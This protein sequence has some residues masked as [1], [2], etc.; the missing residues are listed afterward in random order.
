MWSQASKHIPAPIQMSRVNKSTFI[1]QY[2]GN[3][4]RI[5]AEPPYRK[6]DAIKHMRE[7]IVKATGVELAKLRFLGNVNRDGQWISE[8]AVI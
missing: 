7:V 5:T 1:V 6:R 3:I 8:W 2:N 4:Q